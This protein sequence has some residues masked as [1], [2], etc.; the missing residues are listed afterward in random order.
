MTAS[1]PILG[2]LEHELTRELWSGPLGACWLG[3]ITAGHE[4]GRSV[5]VRRIMGLGPRGRAITDAAREAA[6]LSHP[7]FVKVLGSLDLGSEVRVISEELRVVSARDLP[8]R[9]A[10][11]GTA[12]PPPVAVRIM[13]DALA[14]VSALRTRLGKGA[15][16]RC[17]RSLMPD[18][19]LI[20][21]F[22]ETLLAEVVVTGALVSALRPQNEPELFRYLSPEELEPSLNPGEVY[23]TSEV[24]TAG[25]M[26]WELLAGRPLLRA[27][28]T[29]APP[30][31][32][33]ERLGLPVPGPLARL[34]ERAI[35]ARPER[36]PLTTA[37]FAAELAGLGARLCATSD[38]VG[39]QIEPLL[40][41][42]ARRRASQAWEGPTPFG[43]T[44]LAFRKVAQELGAQPSSEAPTLRPRPQR[45][46]R[47]RWPVILG[48]A[49]LAAG[50][51]WW[52][53]AGVRRSSRGP[54]L[55]PAADHRSRS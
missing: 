54:A 11:R 4:A 16:E 24:Y 22:G 36:R 13:C 47:T 27:P 53:A 9:L 10:A 30:L 17:A 45:R 19:A 49:L 44:L 8:A 37:L 39:E 42:P 20:A 29:P 43:Q 55:E 46:Q 51:L 14:A 28:L 31:D 3:H 48:V 33:I 2:A 1:E 50:L 25:V 21:E 40:Q 41:R 12:L 15:G 18:T 52:L 38:A 35:D 23:E 6:G 34:V 7:A 26:L 32:R 5:I